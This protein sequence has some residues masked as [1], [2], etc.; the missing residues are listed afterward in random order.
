MTMSPRNGDSSEGNDRTS[1]A[2]SFLRKRRLRP[3]TW[4]SE[5]IATVTAPRARAGATAWSQDASPGARTDAGETRSTCRR[6][7]PPASA[8]RALVRE[9]VVGLDDLLHQLVAHDVLL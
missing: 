2:V 6:N 7:R 4:A 8:M 5:T 3:R 9:G 1:V